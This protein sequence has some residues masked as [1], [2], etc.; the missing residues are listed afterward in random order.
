ME[1][2]CA[3]TGKGYMTN[4]KGAP[5]EP[6]YRPIREQENE[7]IHRIEKKRLGDLVT[8]IKEDNTGKELMNLRNS[9]YSEY[10]DT[11]VNICKVHF[12][13]VCEW[14][15][16]IYTEKISSIFTAS[17]EAFALLVF[18]NHVDD[19][20]ELMNSEPVRRSTQ[21]VTSVTPIPRKKTNPR[22]TKA[23]ANTHDIRWIGW[24]KMGIVRFN[25]LVKHIANERSKTG[26]KELENNIMNSY[27]KLCGIMG[28][29]DE[30]RSINSEDEIESVDG[31]DG[32]DGF[33]E[34][35]EDEVNGND[36]TSEMYTLEADD[37]AS[38]P[39]G[40]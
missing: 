5:G 12:I 23:N 1:S 20:Y 26:S 2:M 7:D 29:N 13:D 14:R 17:D 18:E 10:F 6:K 40:V 38:M 30:H 31:F 3:K 19:Y 34:N 28:D 21:T 22:Y 11:F 32:F 33:D 9:E 4:G 37:T 36:N 27:A 16:K 39:T 8:L 25:N 35:G 24:N 15:M